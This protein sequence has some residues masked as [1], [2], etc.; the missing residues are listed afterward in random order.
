[1]VRCALTPFPHRSCVTW[2]EN[3]FEVYGDKAPN[4]HEIQLS[5]TMKK[6][7]FQLYE[8]EQHN[9]GLESVQYNIF[10]N[11]WA[12]LFPNVKSRPW[13]DV[14]GKCSTCY[15]IDR[16]RKTSEEKEVQRH[17]GLAHQMHRGGLFML[18]REK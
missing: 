10:V 6:E 3:H 8:R 5:V 2:L 4:K 7:V 1:M 17:I 9:Q 16:L 14:P 12:S 18:E 15:I 11:L 13:V